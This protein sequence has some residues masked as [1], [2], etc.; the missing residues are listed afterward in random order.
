MHPLL[1]QVLYLDVRDARDAQVLMRVL[2]TRLR[3]TLD[4][5]HVLH[6]EPGGQVEFGGGWLLPF[7]F[8]DHI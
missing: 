2:D 7:H 1:V 4:V 8:F 3:F 6:R 5:G